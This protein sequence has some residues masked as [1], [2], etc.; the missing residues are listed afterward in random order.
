LKKQNSAKLVRRGEQK[1]TVLKILTRFIMSWAEILLVHG[2]LEVVLLEVGPQLDVLSPGCLLHAND[3]GQLGRKLHG[4]GEF[5]S[6]KRC[7][8]SGDFERLEEKRKAG[9]GV[10]NGDAYEFQKCTFEFQPEKMK[11]ITL[12]RPIAS[13]N[14]KGSRE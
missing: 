13:N 7:E 3:F 4:L 14:S 11:R 2:I 5:F 9:D 12:K 8:V 1:G 10:E 6:L